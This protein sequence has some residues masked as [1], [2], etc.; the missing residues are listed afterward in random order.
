M[1]PCGTS[2]TLKWRGLMSA[3]GFLS[4]LSAKVLNFTE[5]AHL[6]SMS[7][8]EGDEHLQAP[9][10]SRLAAKCDSCDGA[11][12]QLISLCSEAPSASDTWGALS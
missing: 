2:A 5:D 3:S 11:R 12:V 7:S 6:K 9:L 1:S 10:H 4:D 8:F